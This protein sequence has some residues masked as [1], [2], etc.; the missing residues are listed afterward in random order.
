MQLTYTEARRLM[1]IA[2]NEYIRVMGEE[3]WN[4]LTREEQ[5]DCLMILFRDIN[6]SL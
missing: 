1:T 4:N 5:H 2:Q 6:N 3:K